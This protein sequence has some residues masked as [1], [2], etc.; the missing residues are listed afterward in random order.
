MSISIAPVLTTPFVL[1]Q[2]PRL[3]AYADRLIHGF[4][5]KPLSLGGA[6]LSREEK[7][8]NRALLARQLGMAARPV[9]AP[10]QVHG[11]QIWTS[12]SESLLCTGEADAML[13]KESYLP[14]MILTAD[15]VPIILYSPNAHAGLVIHSGWRGTALN[16]AGHAVNT[17]HEESGAPNG[18]MIAAIGPA[19]GP[20]CYEVSVEVAEKVCRT[21]A[22]DIS[23]F[24]RFNSESSNP[25]LD[26]VAVIKAQLQQ[27]GVTTIDNLSGCTV[28]HP[29]LFFSHRRG[30][31][32]RQGAILQL[33]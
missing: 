30:D 32:G 25:R 14:V 26:L 12:A 6:A 21:V 24:C 17:L 5:G 20:C 28:C 7:S 9:L 1:Y 16:I 13:V 15:C 18:G 27:A 19:I 22:M 33:L 31:T 10:N 2:S 29:D 11:C 3:N 8:Q 4:S 23:P